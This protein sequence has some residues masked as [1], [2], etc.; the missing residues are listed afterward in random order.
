MAAIRNSF[1]ARWHRLQQRRGNQGNAPTPGY[2]VSRGTVEPTEA[3]KGQGRSR[4]DCDSGHP[5]PAQLQK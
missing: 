4:C 1:R 3:A 2:S 5:T